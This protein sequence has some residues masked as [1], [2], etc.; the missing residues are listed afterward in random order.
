MPRLGRYAITHRFYPS[1][2]NTS[3]RYGAMGLSSEERSKEEREGLA[4]SVVRSTTI[5]FSFRNLKERLPHWGSTATWKVN[6]EKNGLGEQ[7]SPTL[8]PHWS[9]STQ[10]KYPPIR[11]VERQP[12]SF[13][14]TTSPS[15]Q[16][17]SV[18]VRGIS[19]SRNGFFAREWGLPLVSLRR[20]TLTLR[21]R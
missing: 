16:S 17:G 10:P 18:G 11:E 7:P 21:W 3:I 6:A 15:S 5:V 4:F 1:S 19:H 8:D 13:S 20:R 14:Q 2:D 9:N 12:S